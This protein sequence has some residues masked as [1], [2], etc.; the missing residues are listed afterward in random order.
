VSDAKRDAALASSGG[1]KLRTDDAAVARL[2][3]A[4]AQ[5]MVE[6]RRMCQVLGLLHGEFSARMSRPA[7]THVRLDRELMQQIGLFNYVK[8]F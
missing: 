5:T 6:R 3:R 1:G 2:R 4:L 7:S 8:R